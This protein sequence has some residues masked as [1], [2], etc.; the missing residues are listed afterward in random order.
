MV[1]RQCARQVHNPT[2][3]RVVDG[4]ADIAAKAG[5]RGG[6]DDA[7][8]ALDQMRQSGAARIENRTERNRDHPF[9]HLGSDLTDIAES[10]D[11][12]IVHQHVDAVE[13]VHGIGHQRLDFR[14]F[15]H[16]HAP[17]AQTAERQ[18]EGRGRMLQ[19]R[20]ITVGENQSGTLGRETS[21]RGE[22]DTGGGGRHNDDLVVEALHGVLPLPQKM[23][24]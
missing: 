3:R 1:D 14:P 23:L 20:E 11:P 19:F 22:A 4:E 12:G 8:A 15:P 2:L 16:I 10:A 24:A 18:I 7:A 13:R 9:P 17:H 21:C 6:I 5:D